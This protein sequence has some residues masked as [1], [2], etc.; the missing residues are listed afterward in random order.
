LLSAFEQ[1]AVVT[2]S[3][4]R[5][6]DL[7][8]SILFLQKPLICTELDGAIVSLSVFLCCSGGTA[9]KI[10]MSAA[11][12]HHNEATLHHCCG[13][14]PELPVNPAAFPWQWAKKEVTTSQ[15]TDRLQTFQGGEAF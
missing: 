4:Q 11:N 13:T 2:L 10:S 9:A 7:L 3:L 15:Y 6:N 5:N 14:R 8:F 1:P 12:R